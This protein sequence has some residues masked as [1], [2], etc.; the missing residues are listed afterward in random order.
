[1][2]LKQPLVGERIV[3]RDYTPEDLTFSTDM[4]FDPENGRYMSALPVKQVFPAHHSLDIQPEIL[5]RM[6]DAL[7]ELKAAGKLHH[8]SGTFQY[9]DWGIWL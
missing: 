4:W 1:M 6:R 9:E 2:K 8:G 7:R 5:I 3:I